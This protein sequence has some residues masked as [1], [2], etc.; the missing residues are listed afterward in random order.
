MVR[1]WRELAVTERIDDRRGAAGFDLPEISS[2]VILTKSRP[3]EQ[4]A[5]DLVPGSSRV[6]SP[7]GL[8]AIDCPS[9]FE[10]A[11]KPA[12]SRRFWF[13]RGILATAIHNSEC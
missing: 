12:G 13:T 3:G 7:R 1:P 2:E 6:E 8:K 11:L 5:T 10:I 9:L 4:L